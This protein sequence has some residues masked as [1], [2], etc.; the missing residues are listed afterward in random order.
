MTT[1]T[2]ISFADA[3]DHHSLFVLINGIVVLYLGYMKKNETNPRGI[4]HYQAIIQAANSGELWGLDLS[5]SKSTKV[6]ISKF[7]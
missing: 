5:R 3:C 2:G 6:L 7:Y 4:A 1:S